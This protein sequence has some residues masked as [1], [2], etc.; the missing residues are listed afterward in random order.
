[1]EVLTLVGIYAL[2]MWSYDTFKSLLELCWNLW[3]ERTEGIDYVRRYGKWAVVTGG[4]DGIGR[5]YAAFFASK[6]LN[7]A[8]LA[9]ADMKLE[10][11]AKEIQEKYGV[12]VKKIAVD[13]SK[14]FQEYRLIEEKLADI[15]IG[16]LVNNV[17]TAQDPAYFDTIEC[18]THERLVNININAAVMMSRIVLPQMKRRHRGLVI[19]MSSAL[20][21]HPVPAVLMYAASKA[22]VLS[23]SQALREELRPF[24]VECQTVTPFFV[25]TTL[26]K[27][28]LRTKL[29]FLSV[30][31]DRYGKCL[32]T[33]IGRTARTSGYWQHALEITFAKLAPTDVLCRLYH[34]FMRSSFPE[35]K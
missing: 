30:D 34:L 13:F 32:T 12:E 27:D 4:S 6:G 11:V 22:F 29:A 25:K 20:G 14:G 31:V 10:Q 21:I 9:L 5:Q 23:F 19:N 28:F 18:E 17:G 16:V 15:E 3:K 7:V 26:A 8:V 1:M 2:L 33:M 35:M 24:G